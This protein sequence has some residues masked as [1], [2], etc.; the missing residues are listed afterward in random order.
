MSKQTELEASQLLR[1]IEKTVKQ[2]ANHEEGRGC[3]T[4]IY[5]LFEENNYP[6]PDSGLLKSNV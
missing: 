6:M 2:L 4:E 5:E 3:Y 1:H